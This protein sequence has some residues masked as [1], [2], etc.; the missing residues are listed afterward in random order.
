[1]LRK[2]LAAALVGLTA[3]ANAA[4]LPPPATPQNV[5]VHAGIRAEGDSL[6]AGAVATNGISLPYELAID[7]GMPVFNDS[8]GGQQ[9]T[10][11]AM[12]AGGIIPQITVASNVIAAA[13]GTAV[14]A[15]QGIAPTGMA[16]SQ[17]PDYRW[18]Q[19][20]AD[21]NTR[22]RYGFLCGVHGSIGSRNNIGGPPSTFSLYLFVPDLV[23]SLPINCPA[24]SPWTDDNYLLDKIPT[25]IEEGRNNYSNVSQVESD[26]A[27]TVATA[28]PTAYLVFG[29]LKGE[30][31]GGEYTG[32]SGATAI[33]TINSYLASTYGSHYFDWEAYLLTQGN[34]SNIMDTQDVTNGVTPWSLRGTAQT[35]TLNGALGA[36]GCPTLAAT[37]AQGM[38]QVDTG[39]NVE[40][41]YFTTVSG[42]GVTTCSR[43]QG[44]SGSAI[45]H[46]SG[47]QVT[48]KDN[49]HLGT[50]YKIT[51][52]YIASTPALKAALLGRFS[53][54][55]SSPASD[56]A[57]HQ[58]PGLFQNDVRVGGRVMSAQGFFATG[59]DP[60]TGC[61]LN[62]YDASGNPVCA[63]AETAGYL[64]LGG[65]YVLKICFGTGGPGGNCSENV[66][67]TGSHT[68]N[69]SI[70]D[71]STTT[72]S[73]LAA[74]GTYVFAD[75]Q[76]HGFLSGT[77]T[78]AT[79]TI[80]LPT[81]S[82]TYWGK[83]ASLLTMQTI[84]ALTVT[85]TAG[86]VAGAP[87]TISAGGEMSFRC[88]PDSIWHHK[89]AT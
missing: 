23:P 18:L 9:S 89:V 34:S 49:I 57:S 3:S 73:T 74:A 85:A 72:G 56:A 30:Y 54:L 13:F 11:I 64:T 32:Q 41:I 2:F 42:T 67:N 12:R 36:T 87:S 7:L 37:A 66:S 17:T 81:C 61:I 31:P 65:A 82:S 6:M 16:T 58:A 59:A 45:A 8:I 51:A 83:T 5:P 40:Y 50:G 44:T 25:I 86:S 35:T 71:Q 69:D 88:E 63:I 84:T 15:V 27:A 4:N 78:I 1:M 38:A 28:D 47:V 29:I 46:S 75:T 80:Q 77:T 20:A 48:V 14:T 19:T 10:Q 26:I 76:N 55:V 62:G 22:L 70:M 21:D 43:G 39:S 52:D 24:N 79:G 33:N 68:F 60:Y 53:G